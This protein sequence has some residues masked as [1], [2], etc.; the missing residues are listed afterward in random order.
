MAF[1]E[2]RSFAFG[3]HQKSVVEAVA[4]VVVAEGFGT[5]KEE[6]KFDGGILDFCQD[7]D[8]DLYA[9][10]YFRSVGRFSSLPDRLE[11]ISKGWGHRHRPP[12]G[13]LLSWK[14]LE[15]WLRLR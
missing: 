13:R 6:M 8:A 9:I 7:A 11:I 2:S 1:E 14:L 15:Y 10:N 4:A 5:C 12:E 3:L